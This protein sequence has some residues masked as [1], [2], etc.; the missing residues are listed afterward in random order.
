MPGGRSKAYA[1]ESNYFWHQRGR[2][3]CQF[4]KHNS[5]QIIPLAQTQFEE[6]LT[7]HD[8]QEGEPQQDVFLLVHLAEAE[9]QPITQDLHAKHHEQGAEVELGHIMDNLQGHSKG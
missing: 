1:L 2:M 5:L 3:E 9:Q 6:Q 7:N 8:G 4:Q